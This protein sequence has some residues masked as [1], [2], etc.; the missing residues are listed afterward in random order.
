MTEKWQKNRFGKSV[1]A[2]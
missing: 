2:V 1:F